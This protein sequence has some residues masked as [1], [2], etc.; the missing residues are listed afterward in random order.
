MDQTTHFALSLMVP[1]VEGGSHTANKPSGPDGPP[2][3]D[4]HGEL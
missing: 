2:P 3:Q 1:E 4:N